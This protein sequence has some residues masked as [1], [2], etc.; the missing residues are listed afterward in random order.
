M[1]PSEIKVNNLLMRDLSSIKLLS[2]YLFH[3]FLSLWPML[4]CEPLGEQRPH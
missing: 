2:G 1:H 3:L 4:D